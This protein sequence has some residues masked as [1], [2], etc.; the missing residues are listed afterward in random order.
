MNLFSRFRQRLIK[1]YM[2][3]TGAI[4]F[5]LLILIY[6]FVGS[7][8][9]NNFIDQAQMLATEEAEELTYIVSDGKT[10]PD[11]PSDDNH[12]QKYLNKIFYYIYDRD[13][14]LI[15][16]SNK[17]DWSTA[18]INEK[19]TTD[20]LL[21]GQPEIHSVFTQKKDF[22]FFVIAR[23]T[24]YYNG[25]Y[26]GKV[27]A[28]F[29]VSRDLMFLAR[30]LLWIILLLIGVFF[31]INK[32]ANF[33]ANNAMQPIIESFERQTLFAANASHE[34]RTPL[35]V[36]MSGLD[37]LKDDTDNKLSA[38]SQEIIN[39]M[40]DEILNMRT[41]IGNLLLLARSDS[42]AINLKKEVI[43]AEQLIT[44]V[45]N[46][47][48]TIAA[49]KNIE[50]LLSGDTQNVNIYADAK[51]VEEILTILLDNAVKYTPKG[52][53]ICIGTTLQKNMVSIFISN[54]G[55]G[56]AADD[57]PHIFDRFYRSADTQKYEGNG[58]G[59][60]IAKALAEKNDGRLS[61]ASEQNSKTVF[62]LYLPQ[63]DFPM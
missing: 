13:G 5:I 30:L 63:K 11:F 15:K 6:G 55:H 24:A 45:L 18:A 17:I 51:H 8:V 43:P 44:N 38:F 41:L 37:I 62:T 46:R 2:Q 40:K 61:A 52:G 39:D 56:I 20:A 34:L 42:S 9:Y 36:L 1:R 21:N 19:I 50:L 28:G 22:R 29:D 57:L 58:L 60:S 47:F 48:M 16:Y 53:K 10:L 33:M 25:M 14:N 35:S 3:L 27:Y 23:E 49:G 7:L 31:I 26:A 59:L 54:T 4:I 12:T 32:I